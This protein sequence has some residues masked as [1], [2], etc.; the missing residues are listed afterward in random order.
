MLPDYALDYGLFCRS[1]N[2]TS[3]STDAPDT[4]VLAGYLRLPWST[5]FQPDDRQP[6]TMPYIEV[7]TGLTVELPSGYFKIGDQ[8]FPYLELVKDLLSKEYIAAP[9][10]SVTITA[11]GGS[12]SW[13]LGATETPILEGTTSAPLTG[14][15]MMAS[16]RGNTPGAMLR[17]EAI[18][19]SGVPQPFKS[20]KLSLPIEMLACKAEEDKSL[21]EVIYQVSF[22]LLSDPAFSI[23]QQPER[24]FLQGSRDGVPTKAIQFL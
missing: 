20:R 24:Y 13:I 19:G 18:D 11:I 15:L 8:S 16:I 4:F 23:F 3:A 2:E 22:K 12:I 17:I 14:N 1:G 21:A 6:V 7:S 5:D 9:S 10:G